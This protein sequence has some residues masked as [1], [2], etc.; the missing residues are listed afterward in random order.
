MKW[1]CC[2]GC[3]PDLDM[4]GP[5]SLRARLPQAT[6]LLGIWQNVHRTIR[7]L[8]DMGEL[9]DTKQWAMLL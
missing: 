3:Q 1:V 8:L 9:E 7:W 5:Q 2:A 6:R 4:L